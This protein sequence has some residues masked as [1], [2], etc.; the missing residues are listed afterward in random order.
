MRMTIVANCLLIL[1]LFPL[2]GIQGQTLTTVTQNGASSNR[3]DMIFIGDGYQAGEIETT[4]AL[5]SLTGLRRR[6]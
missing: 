2:A 1:V 6:Q 5:A 4:Y 3:V